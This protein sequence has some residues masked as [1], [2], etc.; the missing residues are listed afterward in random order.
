MKTKDPKMKAPLFLSLGGDCLTL[1]GLRL[2]N[3]PHPL[4]GQQRLCFIFSLFRVLSVSR[5][6]VMFGGSKGE[7]K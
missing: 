4:P 3:P 1:T 7:T 5:L 6:V 2:I